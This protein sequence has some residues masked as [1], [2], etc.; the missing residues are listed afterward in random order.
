LKAPDWSVALDAAAQWKHEQLKVLEGLGTKQAA[1]IEEELESISLTSLVA[2]LLFARSPLAAFALEDQLCSSKAPTAQTVPAVDEAEAAQER[3]AEDT[4][5]SVLGD[6]S[7]DRPATQKVDAR[8]K[9][10]KDGARAQSPAEDASLEKQVEGRGDGAKQTSCDVVV[11]HDTHPAPALKTEGS[12]EHE[13]VLAADGHVIDTVSGQ[14]V[15]AILEAFQAMFA[16][17]N[18]E[19]NPILGVLD[20]PSV[21]WV[22]EAVRLQSAADLVNDEPAPEPCDLDERSI[23]DIASNVVAVVEQARAKYAAEDTQGAAVLTEEPPT[24][25]MPGFLPLDPSCGTSARSILQQH[26]P[27]GSAR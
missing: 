21:E 10:P 1:S 25:G 23:F 3:I 26:T 27:I 4:K 11:T 16:E 7:E 2:P 6:H 8:T 13:E 17:G 9:R 14:P 18:L 5:V 12:R 24:G 15:S 20:L 22:L 19:C